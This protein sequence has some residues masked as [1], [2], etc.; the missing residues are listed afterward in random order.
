MSTATENSGLSGRTVS[1]ARRGNF[2][3]DFSIRNPMILFRPLFFLIF[4]GVLWGCSP[5]TSFLK[6][7]IDG[8]SDTTLSPVASMHIAA[9]SK[10]TCAILPGGTVQCWGRNRNGQLGNGGTTDSTLPVGVHGMT[11]AIAIAAGEE[12]T[13]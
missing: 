4:I 12:H 8:P 9:G 2:E 6:E 3:M 5:K 10:H 7:L 1:T 11:T 13:C